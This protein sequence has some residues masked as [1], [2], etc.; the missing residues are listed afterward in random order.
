[1]QLS[2]IVG[3]TAPLLAAWP[4][5]PRQWQHAPDRF[6]ELLTM[7]EV[8]EWV[9]S[10]CLALRNM[11]LIEDGRVMERHE[12]Q[13]RKDMPAPGRVRQHLD[14]GGTLSLRHLETVKPSVS[15]L[16]QAIQEETGGAVHINAY[17][18]PPGCQGLRYHYDPYTTLILQVHGRKTWHVHPPVQ[19]NPT[20]EYGDF[21]QRGFTPEEHEYLATTKPADSFTLEPGTAFWLP[22]GYIHAPV[23]E[24]GGTSVH[25]TV[26]IRE[27]TRHWVA[28]RVASEILALAVKDPAL[29]SV[30]PPAEVTAGPADVVER[31]RAYLLGAIIQMEPA[32]MA[33]L[34]RRAA[35][36]PA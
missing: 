9:D 24:E 36:R 25:L 26:A 22:R 4:E 10:G 6:D 16:N 13:G 2:D 31:M 21:L 20:I 33:E 19:Q 34:T 28:E 11:E 8:N 14:A 15:R 17:V 30:V 32:E 23:A 3:G 35:V 29:R 18:T 27:R 5:E 1:M 7:G 12:Y